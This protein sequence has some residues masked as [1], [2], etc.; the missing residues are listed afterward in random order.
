MKLKAIRPNKGIEIAYKKELLKLVDDM[1]ESVSY[2]VESAYNREVAFDSA[3]EVLADVIRKRVE[4]WQKEFDRRASFIAK[5]FI[6]KINKYTSS[7]LKRD[8][9]KKM[10]TV[11]F[12]TT[13]ALDNVIDSL[14]AEN[15]SLIRSI[16]SR[17]F[18][19]IEVLVQ[20]S[21]R[22]GRNLAY[23][24]D[25]LEKRYGITRRRAIL[26]A[27]DQNNKATESINRQRVLDLGITKGVWKHTGGSKEPRKSHQH[28]SGKE[29]D[30]KKGCLIDGEYIY[31]GQLI[32]CRCS[33]E[34]LIDWR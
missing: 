30:L 9:K 28:A 12:Q 3:A 25:M 16:P 29:F 17:Y 10:P 18:S 21:I 1:Q 4:R 22:E 2:W 32:N 24:T 7:T 5:K 34:P 31:P 26:I 23:L 8:V 13:P 6:G 14:V 11:K 20:H 15:V 19:E 33:F 27:T